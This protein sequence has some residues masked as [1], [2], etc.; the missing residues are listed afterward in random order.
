MPC[1]V[2]FRGVGGHN[3]INTETHIF[4]G[5]KKSEVDLESVHSIGSKDGNNATFTHTIS[6]CSESDSFD[7]FGIGVQ[8]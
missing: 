5:G 3:V 1:V 6:G 4:V 8:D 2:V 7:V